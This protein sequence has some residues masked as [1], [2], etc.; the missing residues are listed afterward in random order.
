MWVSEREC[1]CTWCWAWG[2]NSFGGSESRGH[3]VWFWSQTDPRG[4]EVWIV[5]SISQSPSNSQHGHSRQQHAE[6]MGEVSRLTEFPPELSCSNAVTSESARRAWKKQGEVLKLKETFRQE[7]TCTG[8]T[9]RKR[10]RLR[11]PRQ[12][13][14]LP[15]QALGLCREND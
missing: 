5:S 14:H 4:K 12:G 8:P 11:P 15:P 10:H 3:W 6:S 9:L 1:S 13:Q 2:P 7:R